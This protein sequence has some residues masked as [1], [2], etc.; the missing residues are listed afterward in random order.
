MTRGIRPVAGVAEA[1]CQAIAWGYTLIE[2]G[3][4]AEVPFDLGIHSNG[5]TRLV[6]V[7][8]LKSDGYNG[9]S[10]GRSC[11]IQIREFRDLVLL[12]GIG[13]E[14]WVR[15]QERAWHRYR[16]SPETVEEIAET[17]Q[18]GPSTAGEAGKGG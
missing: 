2:I 12:E 15:G 17:P 5:S 13:R 6:R 1:K 9:E 4:D 8:S 16:I 11:A 10:I 3:M 18:T 7:R 14:L